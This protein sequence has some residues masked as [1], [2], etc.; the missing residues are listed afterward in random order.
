MKDYET[1]ILTAPKEELDPETALKW[2]NEDFMGAYLARLYGFDV[3]DK[4]TR[5]AFKMLSLDLMALFLAAIEAVAEQQTVRVR[6]SEYPVDLASW[7]LDLT[8]VVAYRCEIDDGN[9]YYEDGFSWFAEVLMDRL[10]ASKA[11]A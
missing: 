10:L 6:V 11:A 7:T 2:L 3:E 4:K 8:R 9:G 5:G 1:N